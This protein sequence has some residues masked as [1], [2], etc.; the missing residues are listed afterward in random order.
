MELLKADLIGAIVVFLL[1]IAGIISLM[2]I[3]KD[4]AFRGCGCLFAIVLG[5]AIISC[6]IL[7]ITPL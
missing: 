5:I 3:I 1:G 7:L 6:A 4:S 2:S